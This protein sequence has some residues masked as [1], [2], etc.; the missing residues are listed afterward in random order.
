MK[1]MSNHSDGERD[2]DG[3]WSDNNGWIP[4]DVPFE[5][6]DGNYIEMDVPDDAVGSDSDGD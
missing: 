5:D 2:G 1:I 3:V 6:S 4:D